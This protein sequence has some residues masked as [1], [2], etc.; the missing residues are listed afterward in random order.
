MAIFKPVNCIPYSSTFDVTRDIPYYF[1]CTIDCSNKQEGLAVNGY[2]LTIFDEDNKQ[3]FP[4]DTQKNPVQHISLINDLQKIN[5]IIGT[6]GYY[7]L[8]TGLNGTSLK[9]PV[10]VNNSFINSQ[11]KQ[12][13]LDADGHHGRSLVRN[14]INIDEES[15]NA[16]LQAG[17][18]YKW[19]VTLFQG[20]EE[21]LIQSAI[22]NT[23]VAKPVKL[24]SY[25]MLL[26]QGEVLGSYPERIH[27]KPSE[28]ILPE[29]FLQLYEFSG[30]TQDGKWK[31]DAILEQPKG[32]RVMITAYDYTLGLIYPETG[33]YGIPDSLM[34]DGHMVDGRANG[35][36][37]YKM[38]NNPDNLEVT[39]KVDYVMG[40]PYTGQNKA[41]DNGTKNVLEWT[42]LNSSG[43]SE[44][45]TQTI[46]NYQY[47][48]SVTK[49]GAIINFI[50]MDEYG[51]ESPDRPINTGTRV[52]F[53]KMPQF[54]KNGADAVL[55]DNSP[56]N[57]I[58]SPVDFTL[59]KNNELIITWYRTS[60][61]NT[62]GTLG[63]K[64]I[65][66]LDTGVNYQGQKFDS[67]GNME[68]DLAGKIN[69]TPFKFIKEEPIKLYPDD[70]NTLSSYGVIYYNREATSTKEG[71]VYVKPFSG[72]D[73]GQL[74]VE[75]GAS[76][77]NPRH[78]YISSVDKESWCVRYSISSPI[79]GNE[80]DAAKQDYKKADNQNISRQTKYQI[81]T[82]FRSSDENFFTIYD[83]PEVTLQIRGEWKENINQ[84]TRIYFPISPAPQDIDSGANN[85]NIIDFEKGVFRTYFKGGTLV[86]E[87]YYIPVSQRNIR[88]V[89]SYKQNQYLSWKS[90][91]WFLQDETG[92]T[93]AS[94]DI[95][96]D[97]EIEHIFYGLIENVPYTLILQIEDA[98][99][100]TWIKQTKIYLGPPNI[101]YEL[102][103]EEDT[104]GI[105]TTFN[106][107]IDAV[108]VRASSTGFVPQS[109]N[110][111]VV[112]A[113][114]AANYLEQEEQEIE[115]QS[116]FSLRQS[117]NIRRVSSEL[118]KYCLN[119]NFTP[120]TEQEIEEAEY[121]FYDSVFSSKDSIESQQ[122]LQFDDNFKIETQTTLGF[123]GDEYFGGE[124]FGFQ[125][126]STSDENNFLDYSF[127][128]SSTFLLQNGQRIPNPDRGK[129]VLLYDNF[130]L[131]DEDARPEGW[132]P[133]QHDYY[134]NNTKNFMRYYSR[135]QNKP[136]V[137]MSGIFQQYL[138]IPQWQPYDYEQLPSDKI[139]L[140]PITV[141]WILGDTGYED[142]SFGV[143][144]GPFNI[145][146]EQY[147]GFYHTAAG[148]SWEEADIIYQITS[149]I[150][151]TVQEIYQLAN[152]IASVYKVVDK[153]NDMGEVYAGEGET[154][155][156]GGSTQFV[157][158]GYINN[159]PILFD[160]KS[161]AT[162]PDVFF[163]NSYYVY[164]GVEIIDDII[165]DMWEQKEWGTDG[166]DT[167]NIRKYYLTQKIIH[168]Y[169]FAPGVLGI[170][171]SSNANAI[172]SLFQEG[173]VCSDGELFECEGKEMTMFND[174]VEVQGI[175]ISRVGETFNISG[176]FQYMDNFGDN[177]GIIAL[178]QCTMGAGIH[179]FRIINYSGTIEGAFISIRPE[180]G[181]AQ[182]IPVEQNQR[183]LLTFELLQEQKMYFNLILPNNTNL[184]GQSLNIGIEGIPEANGI[185]P[186]TTYCHSPVLFTDY[187]CQ[188]FNVLEHQKSYEKVGS[189]NSG[190]S[191]SYRRTNY[192]R[193]DAGWYWLEEAGENLIWRDGDSIFS[194]GESSNKYSLLKQ[195]KYLPVSMGER[196]QLAE[197]DITFSVR[198]VF[199]TESFL[200]PQYKINTLIYITP[201]EQKEE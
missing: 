185:V 5:S 87:Y 115:E 51:S 134:K 105:S 7:K 109:N 25:D 50:Q 53:N 160:H 186:F 182:Q 145:Y 122:I 123:Y 162:N 118:N 17:K 10:I 196:G 61:A 150:H 200:A 138:C 91:Q 179:N 165:Y 177:R 124:I 57:G 69:E 108:V 72:L 39:R 142:T 117:Q 178:D 4:I 197:Y 188:V 120:S 56:F 133:Q 193:N 97:G 163:V 74:W 70:T 152:P 100:T 85:Q 92:F 114:E 119:I 22:Q 139:N 131:Y 66:D 98:T 194:Q 8:N 27:S 146:G 136:V 26:T 99:N 167:I 129:I 127:T 83:E 143:I 153:V 59:S 14:W 45:L 199:D 24:Q 48:D 101:L 46:Y 1:E 32:E 12:Y 103:A 3:V 112:G 60:D 20:V 94:S 184:E 6:K 82:W 33:A 65:Y 156:D 176:H 158:A 141:P 54:F 15:N 37:I 11:V 195:Q 140:A 93:I 75:T 79:Y 168:N 175:H 113:Y 95:G 111:V 16:V 40:M 29:Y 63:N 144:E 28:N 18:S 164:R 107:Q 174:K 42:F 104:A 64:L 132:Q 41:A 192:L 180:M 148:D 71:E 67:A 19:V 23:A 73:T 9:F 173:F 130:N 157:A 62:W 110:R 149:P 169:E 44:F 55:V 201:K 96:Y 81:K 170:K 90:F 125:I 36:A 106:S 78:F 159:I 183:V 126:Y 77:T 31:S 187:D 2:A 76:V 128:L 38:T 84:N 21:N 49:T 154:V 198:G 135:I 47:A 151:K 89:A 30:E 34:G 52:V 191:G 43:S 116:T 102:D 189:I 181:Q 86:Q 172:P 13:L 88:V 171:F 35:Y 137:E 80:W 121:I 190:S 147:Y 166:P 68:S 58:Y 161:T 155:E